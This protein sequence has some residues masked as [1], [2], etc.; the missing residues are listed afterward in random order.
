[1]HIKVKM[2]LY[3]HY[4]YIVGWEAVIHLHSLPWYW[5][6]A[7]GR[8]HTQTTLPPK[9]R[10]LTSNWIQSSLGPKDD[11]DVLEKENILR[12][13]RN[14]FPSTSPLPSHDHN[15]PIPAPH[16]VHVISLIKWLS[17]VWREQLWAQCCCTEF[18]PLYA[19]LSYG[20]IHW[21]TCVYLVAFNVHAKPDKFRP[22]W[23]A[24]DI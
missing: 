6:D 18:K 15:Y 24:T 16:P 10:I 3:M 12:P 11:L 19:T 1:M 9:E 23:D 4:R 2:S 5:I 13:T 17:N 21:S 14:W 22:S 7:S 20:T 8:L